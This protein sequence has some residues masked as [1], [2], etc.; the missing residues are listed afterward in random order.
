MRKKNKTKQQKQ[1]QKTATDILK[2]P[3]NKQANKQ[4]GRKVG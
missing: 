4:N 3:A 2:K 1:K